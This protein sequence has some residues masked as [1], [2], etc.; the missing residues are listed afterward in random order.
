MQCRDNLCIEGNIH[1][2]QG[3]RFN[4]KGN[5]ISGI[6]QDGRAFKFNVK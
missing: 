4:L 1:S 3:P 5:Y 2:R 6:G